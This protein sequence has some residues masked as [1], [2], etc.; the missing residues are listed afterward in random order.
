MDGLDN[1]TRAINVYYKRAWNLYASAKT[2]ADRE[3][4]FGMAKNM[5]LNPDL[6]IC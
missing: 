2:T 5:L 1:R 3:E 4:A 6:S